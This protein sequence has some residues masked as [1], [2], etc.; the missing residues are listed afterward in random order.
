MENS[1][2]FLNQ[3]CYRL[4]HSL[5]IK[6]AERFDRRGEHFSVII[7]D[8]DNFKKVNDTYGHAFGDEV[9]RQVGELFLKNAK[10]EGFCARYGGEE[11]AMIL[12]H[13]NPV[14]VAE[15]IRTDFEALDFHTPEGIKHFTLSLGA[16][17]YD[18]HY[19]SG[20]LFFEEADNALYHAKRS[21]KNR[22]ILSTTHTAN[23]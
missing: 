10:K 12:P 20:S 8:I 3:I 5:Q 19:E 14:A 17:I 6:C 4:P 9:I 23:E 1:R 22:V 16:A 18:K 11:F 21:G 15:A 7:A 13:S 2:G